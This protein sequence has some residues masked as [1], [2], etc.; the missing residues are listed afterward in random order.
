M[1]VIEFGVCNPER[2][3]LVGREIK[4]PINGNSS[5][6]SGSGKQRDRKSSFPRVAPAAIQ[7]FDLPLPV[8]RPRSGS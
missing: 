2:V 7:R 3:E 5:T 4:I 8:G 1:N 6:H